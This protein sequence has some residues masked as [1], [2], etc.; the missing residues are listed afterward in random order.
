MSGQDYKKVYCTY[1][2][3][4]GIWLISFVVLNLKLNKSLHFQDIK[5]KDYI[6]RIMMV[7]VMIII[8]I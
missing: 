5:K 4:Y 6:K 2:Q 7:V 8:I 3:V 1:S